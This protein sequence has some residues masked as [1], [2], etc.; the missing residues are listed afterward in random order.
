MIGVALEDE[1]IRG[2]VG[3]LARSAEGEGAGVQR[4]DGNFARGEAP[5][6]AEYNLTHTHTH[7]HLKKHMNKQH[8]QA[9]T[10]TAPPEL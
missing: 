4:V 3:P 7:K 1:R 5:D 8:M 2:L 10:R 9:G 6:D